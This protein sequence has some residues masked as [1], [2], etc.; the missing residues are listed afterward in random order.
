MSEKV[1]AKTREKRNILP[2]PKRFSKK[3]SRTGDKIRNE[4]RSKKKRQR[5]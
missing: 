5:R 1:K 3:G 4:E 2:E